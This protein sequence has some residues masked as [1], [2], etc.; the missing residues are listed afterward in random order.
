[1]S[2]PDT[3]VPDPYNSQSY[4]RF[5][6]TLNNPL[7]YTDPSGYC[8]GDPDDKNNPDKRC[9]KE[10]S[11]IETTYTNIHIYDQ[12]RWTYEELKMIWIALETHVFIN[13]IISAGEINFY[14][15]SWGGDRVAGVTHSGNGKYDITIYDFAKE[16]DP[17]AND[18]EVE[19]SLINFEATII[20]EL[21]HVAMSENPSILQSY[22]AEE[23]QHWWPGITYGHAYNMSVCKGNQDCIDQEKIA[24]AATVL[25]INPG[26][27]QN[28]AGE[29][30]RGTWISSLWTLNPLLDSCRR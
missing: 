3:I 28:G 4:D 21:A 30:W 1:M 7:R 11:L 27:F 24:M 15:Q 23:D 2:Q 26:T 14:R 13:D 5:A 6:Y 29:D 25:Q 20:H 12:G 22:R 17:A 9:W 19:S 16:A 8:T 10:I 18:P